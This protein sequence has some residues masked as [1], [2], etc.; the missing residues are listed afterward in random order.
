MGKAYQC[1]RCGEYSNKEPERRLED[2]EGG[3]GTKPSVAR[4]G[5]HWLCNDCSSDFDDF[6][7][8]G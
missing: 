3:F 1:D 8:N 7:N 6:I 4:V 2:Y 5:E